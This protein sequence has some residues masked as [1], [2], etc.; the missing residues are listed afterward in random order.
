MELTEEDLSLIHALQIR[1]R[2][3]WVELG[4]ALGVSAAALARRW[5]HLRGSGAAWVTAYPLPT[6]E[7]HYAF[8][9]VACAASD[10]AGLR[11]ELATW[12][13]VMSVEEASR[14]YHLVLTVGTP[15]M[16]DLSGLLLDRI[17]ALPGVTGVRSHLAGR[18]HVEGSVWRVGALDSVARTGVAAIHQPTPV[19]DA[20]IDPWDVTWQPL[21]SALARDGRASAAGIAR[22]SGRPVST[23]RRQL[24]RLLRSDVLRIR[25]D[26]AQGLTPYPLCVNWW[27]QVPTGHVPA[28]V[29]RLRNHPRVRQV[30][31]IP[32]PA[33][34][35]F[36]TWVRGLEEA[37]RM[38]EFVED[39]LA[40][41]RVV[42]SAVV[43]RCVKRMGWQLGEQGRATG[44]VVPFSLR[45][46]P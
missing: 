3:T 8:V 23:V 10:L 31:S 14:D 12:P 41:A 33:N 25:C 4:R 45:S 42:E 21:V 20:A 9:E 13:A 43:L 26:V 29:N 30:A 36:T 17:A 16:H 34:L 6:D 11:E 40:P 7:A 38:Q 19:H 27:C 24:T 18:L 15:S 44:T 1:P 5:E 39:E 35:L 37:L 32:G 46:A 22:S 2:A 28:A